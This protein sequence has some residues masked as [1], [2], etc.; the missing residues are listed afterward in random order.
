MHL[1]KF[2][3][4]LI[5]ELKALDSRSDRSGHWKILAEFFAESDYPQDLLPCEFTIVPNPPE[6]RGGYGV[7]KKGTFL[8]EYSV[9]MKMLYLDR[10]T[11]EVSSHVFQSLGILR[12]TYVS[13]FAK[14]KQRFEQE[15]SAWKNLNHP[16][17]LPFLGTVSIGSNRFMVSPWMKWDS[18]TKYLRQNKSSSNDLIVLVRIYFPAKLICRGIY[19]LH[20]LSK[21]RKACTTFMLV[22]R[23]LSTAI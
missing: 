8:G 4:F 2:Y 9:G 5:Q 22:F 1:K 14:N 16:S 13:T 10:A 17:L 12:L 20:S 6:N 3:L 18:V 21:L 19:R 15:V 7:C 23:P 11:P